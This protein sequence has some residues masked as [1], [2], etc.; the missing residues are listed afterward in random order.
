MAPPSP[1][2]EVALSLQEALRTIGADLEAQQVAH[3]AVRVDALGLRFDAMTS[4]RPYR[5]GLA[6]VAAVAE[7]ERCAGTQFDA[8]IAGAF[9]RAVAAG[10]VV[11]MSRA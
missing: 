10:A 3:A 1:V 5:K 8:V 4:D 9:L 7:I 6:L 2:Q 11:P